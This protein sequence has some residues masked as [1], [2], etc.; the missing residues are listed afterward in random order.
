MKVSQLIDLL[1]NLDPT[2]EV[3]MQSDGEGND[4]SPLRGFWLGTYAAESTYHGTVYCDVPAADAEAEEVEVFKE[5]YDL[6]DETY[7]AVLKCPKC[8]VLY[9]IN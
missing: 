1:K 7:A 3:I 4:Y 8:V 9:P 6:N 5:E 2:A